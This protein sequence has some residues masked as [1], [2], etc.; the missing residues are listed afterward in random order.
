MMKAKGLS[1]ENLVGDIDHCEHEIRQ[2][3]DL[4]ESIEEKSD[5]VNTK[6]SELSSE[7]I[8]LQPSEI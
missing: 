6:I 3:R 7:I 2:V 4:I 8:M 5:F 1:V